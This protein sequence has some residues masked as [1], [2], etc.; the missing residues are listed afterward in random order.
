MQGGKEV[1]YWTL[2]ELVYMGSEEGCA[3]GARIG[4]LVTEGFFCM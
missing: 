1:V 3:I 2:K 4:V